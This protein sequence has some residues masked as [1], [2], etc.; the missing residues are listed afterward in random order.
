MNEQVIR[1][2]LAQ[3]HELQLLAYQPSSDKPQI[4]FILPRQ[5]ADYLPVDRERMERLRKLN[6]AKMEAS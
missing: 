6:L 4:T 5:D 3:L 1:I 2:D